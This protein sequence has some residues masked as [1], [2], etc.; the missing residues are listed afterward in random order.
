MSENEKQPTP[1]TAKVIGIWVV[2]A[3]VVLALVWQMIHARGL[4]AEVEAEKQRSADAMFAA[5]KESA[6][7]LA[8]GLGMALAPTFGKPTS[9]VEDLKAICSSIAA[10]GTVA[11]IVVTDSNGRLLATSDAGLTNKTFYEMGT[12]TVTEAR[13][14]ESW[15]ITRPILNNN[16]RLGGLRIWVND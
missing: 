16:T 2:I 3:A 6:I 8:E 7:R 13:E 4:A 14:G 11:T 9:N 1:I 10:K 12:Q 15:V 5:N